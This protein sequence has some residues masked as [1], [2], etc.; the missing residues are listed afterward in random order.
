MKHAGTEVVV[1]A[2]LAS[3]VCIGCDRRPEP[4]FLC[5]MNRV[6]TADP[7]FCRPEPLEGS[8]FHWDEEAC[9]EPTPGLEGAPAH[10]CNRQRVAYCFDPRLSATDRLEPVC[11]LNEKSCSDYRDRVLAAHGNRSPSDVPCLKLRP[12]SV[13]WAH[14]KQTWPPPR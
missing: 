7:L 5:R 9:Q 8:V 11:L 2:T 14:R 13:F 10:T 3:S 12:A 6:T 4:R 1:A